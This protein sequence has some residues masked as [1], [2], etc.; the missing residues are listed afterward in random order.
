MPLY[1]W[2]CE[3]GHRENV[4]AS[5]ADRDGFRPEHTCGMSMHRLVG[6]RGMLYFEEG[7]GRSIGN[8]SNRPVTSLAE[9]KRLMRQRGVVEAGDNVPKAI[10]DNPQTE[11]MKRQL[12]KDSRGRWI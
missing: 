4:W 7:R 3:C 1:E 9:H 5:I 12:E 8:L 11:G 10:R 2:L 6:G